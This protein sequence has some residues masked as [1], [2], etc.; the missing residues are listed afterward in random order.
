MRLLHFDRNGSLCLTK[1]LSDDELLSYPYAILSHTWDE[2]DGE[3]SFADL[4]RGLGSTKVGYKKLRFCGEQAANDG[5]WY[6]WVDT[7]CIDK[8]S[9]AELSKAIT[10]MFRWYGGAVRCY[11]YLKDVPAKASESNDDSS[12][13]W[14]PAFRSSRWFRR[15]W[16]LQE[17]LAP[18]S[19]EF[20][21]LHGTRLGDKQ[22]L[23]QLLHEVTQIPLPALRNAPLDEFGVD[24]RMSWAKHRKTKHG[25]DR[26]Y[27]LLGLFGVSMVPNYGEGVDRAFTRLQKEIQGEDFIARLPY[28]TDAPFNSSTSQHE[29]ACLPNTRVDL[30]KTI[31]EWADGDSE[32]HI[33]WLSGL[34]GTGK[35]T[36]ARSVAMLYHTKQRLGASFFFS[37]GG[38]DAGRAGKFV[39]SIAVQLARSV[40]GVHRHISNAIIQRPE[41]ASQS[42]RDQWKY[43]FLEPLSK[44]EKPAS[45]VLIV[46]ALDECEGID[47][48]QLIVQLLAMCGSLKHV[49]L[50]A[51]LTS[52]PEVHIQYGLDQVPDAK[53]R[54]FVLHRISPS[55][56]NHDIGLFL[57]YKLDLIGREDGED[58]G[59]PGAEVIE[60][61]VRSASGLFIWAATACRFIG[62][63]L[64]AESRLH[65]LADGSDHESATG[66]EGH[67]NQLYLTVLQ[68][69]VQ[70]SY[71]ATELAKYHGLM[72]QIL[73]SIVALSSPLSVL[74]LS[75]LILIPEQRVNRM[76][77]WL[78]A[79]LDIPK[80]QDQPL[81]LH[82]PHF[83]TSSS[84]RTDVLTRNFT[85]KQDMCGMKAPGTLAAE[86]EKDR[87]VQCIRSEVQYACVNWIQHL[88]KAGMQLCDGDQVHIFLKNHFL[89]WLEVL[90][91]LGKVSEG[92]HAI[93]LLESV[94]SDKHSPQLHAFVHDM[95]RFALYGRAAVEQAPLQV[96]YST[97]MFAPSNSAVKQRFANDL[98]AC[99]KRPPQVERE[100]N[101]LLQTLEGHTDWV[102]AV[103]FSPDGKTVA[104]AS[105]D[106]TVTLWDAGT[107]TRQHTL[108]GH[109]GPVMAVVFSP[110]GK[111]VASASSDHTVTLWDAGT[112]TEQHTLR[113][114]TGSVMA[115]VF[116]PDGKTVASESY[117]NTVKLWDAGTGTEQHTL[118]G[119]TD[120]VNAVVF[121][122][123]G[124]TVASA[125][126][127]HTVTLW[128]AGTGTRQHTLVGHTGPVMAVVFSPDG[129]TVASASDDKTVKLWDAGTGTE[130]HTLVGHTGL[131]WAVV[132]SP[133]GKTVASASSDHTVTLWDAG[134]GTRQH[135]LRGHTGSVKA[136]VFS[137]DGKTVASASD[138]NTVKLWDAGTGTEQHTLRGHTGSVMAVVFSPD[139]KTVASESYD[140]T[141]KLWDA[142][143]GTEQHTLVGHTDWVNAVVFS[144][145][146]KTVA[147][148]SSDH[149]VTLWDAGTGTRQH[150]LVGHTGPVMAVVFSPDGKTVASASSDKT[151]KLWD[152]G[153]GAKQH[154]LVGHT[155]RVSAVVFSPD[156][157]TVASASGDKT[158]KLWDAGTGAELRTLQVYG[159]VD[160][161]EYS[162]DSS[163]LITNNGTYPTLLICNEQYTTAEPMSAV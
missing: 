105:S 111:T 116:S 77:K 154:T 151:V 14:E 40:P 16:T 30:L 54:G 11:V 133:D 73:G 79:I 49:R 90:G 109:T 107:G 19:V 132:F 101:A 78:H 23:E 64:F 150:T 89:H 158:V 157:K 155:N 60:G 24:E 153:T 47:D 129:K 13:P 147:S 58:P 123:D 117:D 120:W 106:H 20:F 31:Y 46:D 135:T 156:G 72:R 110:D 112:G 70:N 65:M 125:S 27:C 148:A 61:L 59:W 3:V 36:V 88:T 37:R 143:T 6:F 48:A 51:F 42:L 15:G 115:V 43:L 25:E 92:I 34:A 26:A 124:K 84:A 5:L 67:L 17:L 12:R 62:E 86:V 144:P 32:E 68:K 103:V 22:S 93:S 7:C 139:G 53:R 127:D 74:S 63:G 146:G 138:D 145:D 66:P 94:A 98:P 35:T 162:H 99:I 141:V 126:S 69:S 137:P 55:T 71:T 85:L 29:A 159:Y 10:S 102:N 100:W 118:V 160:S 163:R 128:D 104:S 39:T 75:A 130:Q 38:G 97:L 95:K 50:R 44:L 82:H 80:G 57:K 33:F 134:T 9:S 28:A 142:G 1:D 56:I 136:V 8:S 114:H 83:E 4:N 152:A 91:W 161:L 18:R 45:F 52:R 119:H 2:D 76:L 81:R 108:V 96:Y 113:G 140:N 41:I 122:P 87:I 21:D 131:V 149:T 121:S